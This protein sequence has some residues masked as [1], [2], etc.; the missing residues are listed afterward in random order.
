MDGSSGS[1]VFDA[2]MRLIG[3]HHNRGTKGKD[4][5]FKNNRG[6]PIKAIRDHLICEYPDVAA[7]LKVKKKLRTQ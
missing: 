7:V 3:L 5:Q 2:E 4:G 6:I 1:P